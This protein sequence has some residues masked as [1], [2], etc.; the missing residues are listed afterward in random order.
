[1][2]RAKGGPEKPG[3]EPIV[4]VRAHAAADDSAWDALV[5]RSCNGTML[6]TRRF[7]GYHGGRF[8]DRSLVVEDQHGTIRAVFP[9]AVDPS[10]ADTVT[11]HPGATYGGVV[12]EGWV[13]GDRAIHVIGSIASYYLSHG[14]RSLRYRPVP[15]IYHRVPAQ[16]D[17]HALFQLGTERYRCDLSTTIDLSHERRVRKDRRASL[18]RARRFGVEVQWGRSAL[19]EFW[20]VLE[21]ALTRR[22]GVRPVHSLE[23]MALLA[24]L[25]PDE[26]SIAVAR[27]DLQIAAGAVF[28]HCPPVLHLQYSGSTEPGRAIGA[29]DMLIDSGITAATDGGDRFFDFGVSTENQGRTLNDSLYGYKASFG[30]GGVAYEHYEIDLARA[31]RILEEPPRTVSTLRSTTGSNNGHLS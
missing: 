4:R 10:H 13:E 6:H 19:E 25:F 24:D 7:L 3:K 2:V 26:I 18:R 1:M 28:F 30:G 9:A 11:S 8:V 22:H 17:V 5:G 21:E 27:A 14:F 20:P 16:D 23:E 12:H 29:I 31:N 15:Y